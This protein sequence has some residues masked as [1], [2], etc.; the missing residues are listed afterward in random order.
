[1]EGAHAYDWIDYGDT[2]IVHDPATVLERLDLGLTDVELLPI[3][4]RALPSTA[5]T[6]VDWLDLAIAIG[7]VAID[8]PD[9]SGIVVMH[10]T[11]SMEETAFFLHLVYHQ[12]IP[13]VLT[14][15][16]RPPN[17]S[18]SD[19]AP[20]LRA[21][22]AVASGSKEARVFVVMDSHI[23]SAVDVT[24]LANHA[25]DAFEAPEFGP[26]GRVE[27]DGSIVVS[28][29]NDDDLRGELRGAL[30]IPRTEFPRVDIAYSYAGADG[31]AIASFVAAGARG[32]IS[33]G[34][35]PGRSTP[36]ER[37]ALLDA[38]D[39][40]VTVVQTSRAHRGRVPPQPYNIEA[41]VLSGGALGPL[42][43]RILL[44]LALA[45]GRERQ[46]IQQMLMKF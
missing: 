20:N 15:A 18:G 21:A 35:P 39:A 32:I 36:Q 42:K 31:V 10:G 26:L 38:L 9:L 41:G 33:A 12:S 45:Q 27:A 40:G 25:L 11:A 28:R 34:F 19:A 8:H 5:I 29:R 23:Y 13:L 4:F 14:G 24:K 22:I 43:A 2:G 37:R 46:I 1:M 3:S 30:G 16:Q 17:T 44:M 7:R 6:P